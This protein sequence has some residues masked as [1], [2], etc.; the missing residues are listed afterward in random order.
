MLKI[1][2]QSELQFSS[3]GISMG[4]GDDSSVPIFTSLHFCKRILLLE[5]AERTVCKDRAHCGHVF[6]HFTCPARFIL[7]QDTTLWTVSSK[8]IDGRV[9][10]RL[11]LGHSGN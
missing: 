10:S 2:L 3:Q 1:I 4:Y 7:L 6:L 8:H 5:N 11:S 9:H